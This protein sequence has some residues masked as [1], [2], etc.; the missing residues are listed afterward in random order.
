MPK[1]R[2]K[3]VVI[4][5]MLFLGGDQALINIDYAVEFDDWLKEN[6]GERKCRYVGDTVIIPTLEGDHTASAGDWI[7]KGVQGELYPCK[8]DIFDATYESVT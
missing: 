3:P 8:P 2:K 4:E 7:I 6:Q 1:F 5:A